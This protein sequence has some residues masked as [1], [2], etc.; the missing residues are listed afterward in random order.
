MPALNLHNY[1]QMENRHRVPDDFVIIKR[2]DYELL[3]VLVTLI[4]HDLVTKIRDAKSD[5]SR[6]ISEEKL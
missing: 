4:P 1:P 2:D 5:R 6:N 3:T